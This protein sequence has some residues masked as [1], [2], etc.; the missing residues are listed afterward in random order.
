MAK[1][2]DSVGIAI[3]PLSSGKFFCLYS[4]EIKGGNKVGC[5]YHTSGDKPIPSSLVKALFIDLRT[6]YA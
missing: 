2:D 6:P 4:A 1:A 3:A 5:H